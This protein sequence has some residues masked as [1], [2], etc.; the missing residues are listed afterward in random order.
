[1]QKVVTQLSHYSPVVSLNT[2]PKP[3]NLSL[4]LN[5]C[6]STFTFL[7]FSFNLYA[8]QKE[9]RASPFTH[10]PKH[11]TLCS[12]SNKPIDNS[13]MM[14]VMMMMQSGANV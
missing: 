8:S 1:M 10:Y 3:I 11:M 4:K 14:M 5:S 9:S 2:S 6:A 7:P 13:M 12:D